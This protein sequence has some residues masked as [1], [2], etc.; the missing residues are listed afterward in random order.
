LE[1]SATPGPAIIAL[2]VGYVKYIITLFNF[3][4]VP[5]AMTVGVIETEIHEAMLGK[6][7]AAMFP[8]G[9]PPDNLRFLSANTV[10][11]WRRLSMLSKFEFIK[12]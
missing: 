3:F 11:A 9:N 5:Q 4:P 7:L 2:D 12:R 10:K 1:S 6:R 8:N